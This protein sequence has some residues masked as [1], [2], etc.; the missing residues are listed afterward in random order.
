MKHNLSLHFLRQ[1]ALAMAI[2]L[3]FGFQAQAQVLVRQ[4]SKPSISFNDAYQSLNP[5]SVATPKMKSSIEASAKVIQATLYTKQFTVFY[6][7][8]TTVAAD[9]FAMRFAVVLDSW[10]EAGYWSMTEAQRNAADALRTDDFVPPSAYAAM[11][12]SLDFRFSAPRPLRLDNSD[13]NNYG[14]V[15]GHKFF[16]IR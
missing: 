11:R 12:V 6:G 8:P 16:F 2:I 3:A 1:P 5:E 14:P 9:W 4:K 15:Q 10:D 7:V 13:F